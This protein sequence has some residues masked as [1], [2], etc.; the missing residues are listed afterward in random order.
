M[1]FESPKHRVSGALATALAA[2]DT[3]LEDET[4]I[5]G[6]FL[7]GLSRSQL[8][9]DAWDRLHAAALRDN[10]LAEVAFAFEEL[11]QDRRLKTLAPPVVAEF[12]FHAALFFGEVFGD[13]DGMIGYLERAIAA[14]PLHAAAFDKLDRTLEAAGNVQRRAELHAEVAGHLPRAEQAARWKRAADLFA[15]AGAAERATE[16]YQQVLRIDP[17][18]EGARDALA[19]LYDAQGRYRDLVRL[20]EG[21]LPSLSPEAQLVQR[22]RLVEIY[23]AQLGE[24]DKSVAHVE[25]VLAA[26]PDDELARAVANR[27]LEN[28]TTAGRAAAALRAAHERLGNHA[29]VARLL[30]I[31]L[32]TARGVHRKD[33]LRRLGALRQDVL[34]DEAGAFEALDQALAIDPTDDEV[35]ERYAGL[36]RALGRQQDA[37]K[38]LTRVSGLAKD[39]SS[40]AR[41]A[42]E[43]GSLMIALGDNR[44]AR[45][46][47]SGALST[48]GIDPATAAAAAHALA[49]LY[50]AEGDLASLADML[51]RVGRDDPDER[52]RNAAWERLAELAG[53]PLDDPGKAIAAWRGL[54]AAGARAR[55]LAA[56]E[57]LY[58]RT[59]DAVGLAEI[60]RERARDAA[61]PKE[62]RELGMRAAEA[63]SAAAPEQAVEAWRDL[64]E[65]HGPD[66]ELLAHYVP[67]LESRGDWSE[68]ARIHAL[69]ARQGS[70]SERASA[71]SRL[72]TVRLQR[73]RDVPG[74]LDALQQAVHADPREPTAIALLE[75]LLASED[76]AVALRAAGLLEPLYRAEGAR[77]GLLR[78]LAVRGVR[79]A[80]P[81]ER[82]AALHQALDLALALPSEQARGLD[83]ARRGLEESL[84]V[85][86][87][88]E[89]WLAGLRQ[90]ARDDE[91]GLARRA[92]V[93][94]RA[95]GAR[96]ADRKAALAV[97]KETG[98]TLLAAGDERRALVAF[99][100]ALELAPASLEILGRVEE[101]LRRQGSPADRLGLY[102]AALERETDRA[103]RRRLRASIASLLQD[104]LGDDAGAIATL[105]DALNEDP[106]D[107]RAAELLT[108]LYLRGELWSHALELLEGRIDRAEERA[109]RRALIGRAVDVAV[110]AG[111]A[112]R[113]S[114]HARALL[115][116][117]A[118]SQDD[119]DVI[120]HIAGQ[121]GDVELQ[122]DVVR[123][124]IEGAAGVEDRVFW[125]G[126]LGTLEATAKGDA[127]AAA[128]TWK[129]AAAMAEEAGSTQDA[130]ALYERVRRVAPFDVEATARLARLLEANGEKTALPELYAVLAEGASDADERSRALLRVAS[131]L[132]EAGD[133]SGA[134]DAATRAFAAQPSAPGGLAT[135]ERLALATGAIDAFCRAIDGALHRT[136]G[137][138][139]EEAPY[140]VAWERARARVLANEPSRL[141]EALGH[142]RELLDDPATPVAE[143]ADVAR[144]LDELLAAHPERV[145]ERRWLFDWRVRTADGADEQVRALERWADAEERELSDPDQAL[146]LWRRVL[147]ARPEHA[148]ARAS[149]ARLLLA[150]GDVEGAIATLVERV[151]AAATD[152][153]RCAV[154]LDVAA[155]EAEIPSRRGDALARVGLVLEAGPDSRA[156]QIASRIMSDPEHGAA[157]AALVQKHL[158]R[159]EGAE[160]RA[161]VLGALLAGATAAAPEDR[162]RWHRELVSL[163]RAAGD[164][165]ATYDALCA[166]LPET[167]DDE[168]GWVEAEDLARRTNEPEPLAAAYA[169]VLDRSPSP[170][171]VA[172]VGMRAV[173][174]LEEWFEDPSRV[175]TTLDRIVDV[176]P[177]ADWAF[178]RLKLLYDAQERWDD[179][180]R[181]YDRV[182]AVADPD[183]RIELLEDAAQ[184]AKDFAGHSERAIGYLEQLVELKPKNARLLASLE[185]LYE[186]HERHRSLVELLA[187]RLPELGAAEAQQTRARM[188]QLWLDPLGDAGAALLVIEEMLAA[189]P[190]PEVQKTAEELLS[191]VLS[192]APPTEEV[193]D[194][195]PPSAG[196]SIAPP[197]ASVPPG[198]ASV[199]PA[200]GSRGRSRRL[201][202]R[203]RAAAILKERF[204]AAGRDRELVRVLEIELETVKNVKERIRRHRELGEL[205]ERLGDDAAALEHWVA[206][207][208]LE[209]ESASHRAHLEE[210]AARVNRHDRLAEVLAAAADDCNDDALRVDLLMRAGAVRADT[211]ADDAHAIELFGRVLTLEAPAEVAL[212][213][214]RRL[215]GLLAAAGRA[216]ERLAVLERMATVEPEPGRRAEILGT[217]ARLAAELGE[218]ERAIEAWEARLEANPD[219]L[220]ALDGLAALLE[221][222][223]RHRPLLGVLQRRAKVLEGKGGAEAR[224]RARDDRMR[225]ATLLAHELGEPAGAIAE[226]EAI[227]QEH[228]ASEESIAALMRLY[229]EMGRWSDLARLLARAAGE[230]S[231]E[232]QTALL[233]RLGDI[234]RAHLAAGAAAVTSYQR[235]LA[236]VPTDEETLAGLHALLGDEPEVA[237]EALRVLLEAYRRTD[238]W[239]RLLD[240]TELR[241]RAAADDA[242]R[243][244]ILLEVA[245]IAEE[246]AGDVA[247]AFDATRKAFAIANGEDRI[248]EELVR[249]AGLSGSWKALADAHRA[250]IDAVENG[251]WRDAELVARLRMRLGQ[252]LEE[253]LDDPRAALAA[254]ARVAADTPTDTAAGVAAIRAAG[255]VARWDLVAKVIVENAVATGRISDTL[256][257]A[258]EDAATAPAA[259]DAVTG[260]FAAAVAERAD[261]EARLARDLEARL[262]AWHLD[263]RADLDAAEAAYARALSHDPQ[264]ADILRHLAALQRRAKGRPL[265]DS[266]LRL[267]QAT[268]GDLSL[269]REAAEVATS[270]VGD[271]G[272]AKTIV[273]RMLKLASERWLAG[274]GPLGFDPEPPSQ[275]VEWALAELVRIYNEEGNAE[276]I[277]ELLVE[278]S[279]LPFD[280]ERARSMRH[281]AG[282]VAVGRVGDQEAALALYLELFEEDPHDREAA[283]QLASLYASLGR[284]AQLLA[285]RRRQVEFAR[286]LDERVA[287]RLEI[288]RLERGLGHAEDAIAELRANLAEMPREPRTVAALSELF[289]GAA[290][291]S[292][293]VAL[294]VD[295]AER[296]ERDGEMVSACDFWSRAAEIAE[297]ELGDAVSAIHHHRQVVRMEPRPESL[298]AL[299]RLLEGAGDHEGAADCLDRLATVV[300]AQDRPAVIARLSDALVA[301]GREDVARARLEVALESAPAVGALSDRL[302][303]LYRRAQMWPKLAELLTHAA[304]YADGPAQRLARL[305]EA[306]ELQA[307]PCGA[308]EL[309]IPLLEEACALAPDDRRLKLALADALGAAG[310]TDRARGLLQKLVEGFGA[311][312][313]KERAQVHFHL[314]RLELT[315]GDRAR[316]LAELDAA[317]KIDPTNAEI[318]RMVGDL[319]RDDGQLERA[320]RAFRGLLSVVRKGEDEEREGEPPIVRSEVLVELADIA[321][322]QGEKERGQEILESAF[323]VASGSALEAERLER[324]LRARGDFASLARALETRIARLEGTAAGGEAMAQLAGVLDAELGR[325][326]DAADVALRAVRVAPT[327][328]AVHDTA[329]SLAQRT[330]RFADYEATL[331]EARAA[332]EE[333]SDRRLAATL[334]LRHARVLEELGELK[335]AAAVL[336]TVRADGA[337][338]EVL[339]SLDRLYGA[340]GDATGQERVLAELVEAEVETT[341]RDPR[342]AA[343]AL[344]RLAELRAKRG[345]TAAEAAQLAQTA[346]DLAPDPERTLAILLAATAHEEAGDEALDTLERFARAASRLDAVGVALERRLARPDARPERVRAAIESARSLDD[347]QLA[348]KLLTLAEART[349]DVHPEL[350]CQALLARATLLRAAGR[351][352]EAEELRLGAAALA[353]PEEARR[354]RLDVARAAREELADAALEVRA[355]EAARAADD[356]DTEVLRALVDVY[357]RT[358]QLHDRLADA[359]GALVDRA[360]DGDERANLRG[361]RAAILEGMGRKDEAARELEAA[362][363][364]APTRE[365]L[366]ERF[367]VLLEGAGR[368]AELRALLLR[369]LDA[370]KDRGDAAAVAALSLRLGGMLAGDRP[371][372]ARTVYVGG[373]DWEPENRALLRAVL[374]LTGPKSDPAERAELLERFLRVETGPETEPLAL[375]LAQNRAEQWDND[376]AERALELGLRAYPQSR[377]I[378]NKLLEAYRERGDTR[379]LAELHDVVGAGLEG[380]ER[381]ERLAEAARLYQ[382][383]GDPGAA[384][385]ALLASGRTD[386]ATIRKVAALLAS[387]GDV[388]AADRE[389]GLA[390]ERT[391]D[392]G[393]RAALFVQRSQVRAA[394][395][396]GAGALADA[397]QAF[398]LDAARHGGALAARLR[399]AADAE[400]DAVAARAYRLRAAE[401][402]SASGDVALARDVLTRALAADA[403]DTDALRALARLESAAGDPHAAAAALASLVAVEEP[404]MLPETALWLADVAASADPAMAREGLEKA[405]SAFPE[406]TRL[407]ARLLEVYEKTDAHR[408]L[409][410]LRIEMARAAEDVGA[411]F[412]ALVKAGAAL[413]GPA[414]DPTLALQVL[415]EA[416]ELRP[417]DLECGSLLAEAYFRTGAQADAV[418]LLQSLVAAQRGRRSRELA[419]V[420]EKLAHIERARGDQQSEMTYLSSA[421]DMDVQNGVVAAA[422]ADVSL[423]LGQIDVATKA[424]RAVTMLK[425]PGPLPKAVAY[426]KLGE[427][428]WQQGDPKRAALLLKRAVDEDPQLDEARAILHRLLESG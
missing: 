127:R 205:L 428:A 320:E 9:D 92:E 278:T 248:A 46:A 225:M 247:M 396:D 28:K 142:M 263:R 19:N 331:G 155:I 298:D 200:R 90:I 68:L 257:A 376:G 363:E 153:E 21:A 82:L 424:L 270:F 385:R 138:A 129:R 354:L 373:L 33:V 409:A 213:A 301:A 362:L 181:L 252:V 402:A 255:K 215:N 76:D 170:E 203:Q 408:E 154:L 379:K 271:R 77:G 134:F 191:R 305:R 311:R 422:L 226:W 218:L 3:K 73:L 25:A 182:L 190:T 293:W 338:I 137:D 32:E 289:S 24:A 184:I 107:A 339:R 359:I 206:L 425:V 349:R 71:A 330:G 201:L 243:V 110:R 253:H 334:A 279:R 172:V 63:L 265:I 324:A 114:V 115:D 160:T 167:W 109:A 43:T 258:L 406:D 391:A 113:A 318:L 416:F 177:R 1:T 288:A 250:V 344:F 67:I 227:E 297:R 13:E 364:E 221:A 421:L 74:A 352:R 242:Q 158:D 380:E 381:A 290:R 144:E 256:Q 419:Q 316:A 101:L 75:Q 48:P 374:A 91:E 125:L 401:I 40:R 5:L 102:R 353:P 178:D 399:D 367:A 260:A 300:A 323:E 130:R 162:R 284:S 15:H 84:A 186:R 93:L 117:P 39:P 286:A 340:L 209:P 407:A 195:L 7:L 357:E 398:A 176:D 152:E 16:A 249:L 118:T 214:C 57:P 4:E 325:T 157:A 169:A 79:A 343:T 174:F 378:E 50:E 126:R 89:P 133:L 2:L 348:E 280:T 303:V 411:R 198:R 273:E 229:A 264:S 395:G 168:D 212:A 347:A 100:R 418:N 143:R 51:E 245:R 34:G 285:L 246:R 45:A 124:R 350:A 317:T 17:T 296:A 230:A 196:E 239:R 171:T 262:A 96:A 294:L 237:S 72:A 228:G 291:W 368:T 8:P 135:L 99:R 220:E 315:T 85:G 26:A 313:P 12:M 104:E 341:S 335:R 121:V 78:A 309:A 336:E 427:I 120:E 287:L 233:R 216:H 321:A 224:S 387:A 6:A 55:A 56:L 413:L 372:E 392:A 332:A 386:E 188:A 393:L 106:D 64:V 319:A 370:A 147:A 241:L 202:V 240:L 98:E 183:R 69:A 423:R 232:A 49:G 42:I 65:A 197:R 314:A 382:E 394:A 277:V 389:L 400:V 166:A 88:V 18:D 266:L 103:A 234:Q 94:F 238:A 29:E 365:D 204:Q 80:D 159:A 306:A 361:R 52:R 276:R 95:L 312:R 412:E 329:F 139:T 244:Q 146:A 275:Y 390:I 377:K 366:A 194:S 97:A 388:G 193:R 20:L 164:D 37:V 281:E 151:D 360:E 292:D 236:N 187:R 269:L 210:L 30:A 59:G 58:Q 140:R 272:L 131:L 70:L 86:A 22:R 44:R 259:W 123:R 283:E 47:L 328:M 132:E 302:A 122:C 199:A 223:G 403:R 282:R 141:E 163:R 345:T 267:S 23:A 404:A 148:K 208:M 111:A 119:L 351:G 61:N 235:A 231:G 299:A 87:A 415:G 185:R 371:E 128:T 41:I 383:A 173:E 66:A 333:S 222:D 36:A 81:A 310:R 346:H 27:L 397:E 207:V 384:A 161:T 179:L 35:R 356:A 165:R 355:W 189:D 417:S 150:R 274:P 54:L 149:V 414:N 10:R 254:Y 307:G 180:F 14:H 38:T 11:S 337:S 217:A 420:Y 108:E 83:V 53:G 31:E 62:R 219:D 342:V 358:G 308:P 326:A 405:R 369:R 295:Q 192:S 426:Q 156:F 211:L 304:T 105:T 410:L 116:D 136:L 327:S 60:L 175:A 322:R 268:G 375:E 112:D 145:I 251:T 261:L